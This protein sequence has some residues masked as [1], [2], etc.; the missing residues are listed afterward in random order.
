[1]ISNNFCNV[2]TNGFS[3][4]YGVWVIF[5]TNYIKIRD[6]AVFPSPCGV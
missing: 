6:I 2:N 4:P 1:M 5:G 3:S